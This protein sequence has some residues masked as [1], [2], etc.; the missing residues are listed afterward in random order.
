[1]PDSKGDRNGRVKVPSRSGSAGDDGKGNANGEG[2]TNLK[3]RTESSHAKRVR[4]IECEASD[5]SDSR[6]P[7]DR[8][9]QE[10]IGDSGD[11]RLKRKSMKGQMS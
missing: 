11:A 3:E 5:R 8:R 9:Q 6:K 10:C 2:P 7:K 1:M 4:E